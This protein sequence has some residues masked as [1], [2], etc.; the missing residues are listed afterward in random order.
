MVFGP[1][2][3]GRWSGC[4]GEGVVQ[5][6]AEQFV[7]AGFPRPVTGQV[8]VLAVRGV[9]DP[10]RSV[11]Q[12]VA[13]GRGAGTGMPAAGQDA[14]GAGEVV[15]DRGADQPGGVRGER[16]GGQVREWAVLQLG[17]G[18]LDDG[19]VAVGGSRRPASVRGCR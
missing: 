10:H 5:G 12:L 7:Q 14:G 19:V 17:D 1:G 9:R 13:Q 6:A 4:G 11:D 15:G 3:F 8:Q 2:P 18:L 16:A